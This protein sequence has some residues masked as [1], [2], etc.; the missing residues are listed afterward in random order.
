MS[1]GILSQ[2]QAAQPSCTHFML[3]IWVRTSKVLTMIA[4][5]RL[6][7][8]TADCARS[9]DAQQEILVSDSQRRTTQ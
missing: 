2:L 4:V 8:M 3:Y 7:L 5:S 6:P 9:I 1:C